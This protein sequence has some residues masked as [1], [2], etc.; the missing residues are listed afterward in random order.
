VST[1]QAYGAVKTRSTATI[2]EFDADNLCLPIGGL[3]RE[4]DT[5]TTTRI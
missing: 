5:V 2:A 4:I 3:V 1:S